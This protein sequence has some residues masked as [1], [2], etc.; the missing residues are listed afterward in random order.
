MRRILAASV[1]LSPLLLT[2]SAVA[3]QP[4]DD[5]S[6]STQVRPVST[7]VTSPKIVRSSDIV[8]PPEV[9][10]TIPPDA[11]VVLKLNIDEQGK[12]EDIQIV[13]AVNALLGERV[14][15]AVSNFRWRPATLDKQPIPM[16]ITL[17][18]VVEH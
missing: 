9:A 4:M 15:Q 10:A 5:S 18:V 2:A 11:E 8:L 3:S 7:G 6:A 13:K 16:D 12:P 14:A 17:N 1:L